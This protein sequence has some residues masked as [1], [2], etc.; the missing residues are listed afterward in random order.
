MSAPDIRDAESED[1]PSIRRV[2]EESWA[3]TYRDI[4]PSDTQRAAIDGWYS[5][6]ALLEAIHSPPSIF[7]VAELSGEVIAFAQCVISSGTAELTRMYV[8]P[9]HQRSR[10]GE[11]L[12]ARIT[13]EL[14]K[15]RVSALGISVESANRTARNFYA[16][17][18]FMSG[19]DESVELFGHRLNLT[20]YTLPLQS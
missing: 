2:A 8:L 11:A 10:I 3:A 9:R 20:R 16:R 6:D 15:R 17:S 4:I 1:A 14:R 7:Y 19:Q 13:T 18:G 5:V 12:L